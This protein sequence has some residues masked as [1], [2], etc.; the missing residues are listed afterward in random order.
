[1]IAKPPKLLRPFSPRDLVPTA[2]Q[3]ARMR[4]LYAWLKASK[5]SQFRAGEAT[6]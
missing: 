5:K 3:R 1:M 6:P 4:E 2:A